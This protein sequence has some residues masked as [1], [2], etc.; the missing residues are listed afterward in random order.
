MDSAMVNPIVRRSRAPASRCGRQSLDA[1]CGRQVGTRN[2]PELEDL[3]RSAA[4]DD[5]P[6]DRGTDA[7]PDREGIGEGIHVALYIRS[8]AS[9]R[10][11]ERSIAGVCK[12]LAARGHR[13]DLV[14]DRDEGWL[15]E[16]LREQDAGVR[17]VCLRPP[18][19]DLASLAGSLAAAARQW[20]S[21]RGA[22]AAA[23]YAVA[24]RL[25]VQPLRRYLRQARPQVLF[26]FLNKANVSVLLAAALGVPGTRVA[27]T[28]HN[29]LSAAASLGTSRRMLRILPVL[30]P[31]A[32]R[33]VA[34]SEGVREDLLRIGG[35][36]DGSP[37]DGSLPDGRV[38]V[39]HNPVFDDEILRLAAAP[40][41]HL[42]L[43]GPG[44]GG[45]GFGDANVPV[46]VAA[47]KLS[48]QKDYPTLLEAFAALRQRRTALLVIL[49]DGEELDRLERLCG[50]LGIARD[51]RF[52]G[53]V[54]NPY[55][56][57]RHA[58]VFVM[59]SRH[60]GMPTALIEAMACG[61]PVVST[62][63]PSGPA[64]ILAAGRY[65]RLVPVGDAEALAEAIHRTLEAP[66]P[67]Q[68]LVERARAFS[69]DRAI[70]GY[71]E[72]MR[73]MASGTRSS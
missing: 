42:G 13:V 8:V 59:S 47:G 25:P 29:T 27:V 28:V 67:R 34:V 7:E 54:R 41:D 70:D 23:A 2:L 33:A 64:E 50:D 56:F 61:C 3:K 9:G 72:L 37:R 43:G 30:L 73:A 19:L 32:A 18:S 51:V 65:G 39:L 40:L 62:D 12:G 1:R 4:P 63:C 5:P 38:V 17:I 53:Y 68:V 46:L 57:F 6:E 66:V 36:R 35:P 31:Y 52:M 48:A 22:A 45:P 71:E 55:A 49:G 20:R 58:S 11:A 14:V 26:S 16:R 44:L 15:L 10:G 60:E 24:H 21:P 69:F